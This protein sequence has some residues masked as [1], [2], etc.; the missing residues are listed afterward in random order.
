MARARIQGGAAVAD[1][2]RALWVSRLVVW[3]AGVGA[4]LAF[5][6][7]D[8]S[9]QAFDPD[10]LTRPFGGFGDDLLAPGARWDAVWFLRI[11]EDGYDP[12]PDRAAFFP[13]YP[14]LVRV[15]GAVVG[16]PAVAGIALSL[17][18]LFGALVL[19][20]RLVE[21]DFDRRTARLCVLLV[22]LFPG[23]VWFSSVYSE[24][25]F[26]L[27]SVA[28]VYL[29]RTDRWLPAALAGALAASTRS[30][31]I[32]LLVPLALLWWQSARRPRDL[33]AVVVLVPA[34]VLAFC[35]YC[36]ARGL[37]F[38]APFDAQKAWLRVFAGPF[39]AVPDAVTAAW[40]GARDIVTGADRP[41][42]PFDPARVN[43]ELFAAFAAVLIAALGAL[44]RLPLA[45]GLYALAALA[46]PLSYP[47]DGQP[48]MSL[49]RF[50]AVLWP[51][52]LWLAVVVVRRPCA[53]KVIIV[54]MIVL[55]A[56]VSATVARWGWV[57]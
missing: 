48:L 37:P 42:F 25:L 49:P 11:A 26:L 27:L 3:V 28:A 41:T 36:A 51:L 18:C 56:G 32:V 5:G 4:V 16:E 29:A 20:H 1:A 13:L 8:R 2:W 15:L 21:L 43:V 57:A 12:D 34:G 7:M 40:H 33:A 14:L 39:G 35:A 38:T 44:R 52:H 9:A 50:A 19:L 17:A 53:R 47:V 54:A 30:A 45:Y 46:I 55:S 24:S 6:V 31:G 23:A 10:G 22:A